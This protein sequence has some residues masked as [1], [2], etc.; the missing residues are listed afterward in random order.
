MK[1]DDIQRKVTLPVCII[2]RLK[3]VYKGK[4]DDLIECLLINYNCGEYYSVAIKVK[5]YE[6]DASQYGYY[7]IKRD[8]LDKYL[9]T[10]EYEI[11]E[12]KEY[13]YYYRVEYVERDLVKIIPSNKKYNLGDYII[14]TS[15]SKKYS[16]GFINEV[17]LSKEEVE[18]KYS[19]KQILDRRIICK[20]EDEYGEKLTELNKTRLNIKA[21]NKLV[22]EKYLL[23]LLNN[24]TNEDLEKIK[25][26]LKT[27][28]EKEKTL[29]KELE[30]Y[31]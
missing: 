16:V 21:L 23:L 17:M 15:D 7:Y 5:D 20:I 6:N 1:I 13:N 18:S 25:S 27:L 8:I 30:Q 28:L 11:M 12:N 24:E 19:N 4:S 3:S 29:V 10:G 2:N 26:D 31:E 14:L 9:N 22:S